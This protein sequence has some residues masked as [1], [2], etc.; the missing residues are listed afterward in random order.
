MY[1]TQKKLSLMQGNELTQPVPDT[2]EGWFCSFCF[3]AE[4]VHAAY[5]EKQFGFL[6]HLIFS[7]C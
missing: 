3:R 5:Q 6:V 4:G 1:H 2:V 7:P